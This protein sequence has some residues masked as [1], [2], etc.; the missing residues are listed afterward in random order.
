MIMQGT[1]LPSQRFALYLSKVARVLTWSRVCFT[2]LM[3]V[4]CA[5][6]VYMPYDCMLCLRGEHDEDVLG[7]HA[8]AL[9]L[10]EAGHAA[11]HLLLARRLA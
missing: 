7:A 10:P 2:Q 9:E 11:P 3:T 8:G 6:H 1:L 5:E 4:L